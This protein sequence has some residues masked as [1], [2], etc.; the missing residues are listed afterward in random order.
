MDA[1]K[2]ALLQRLREILIDEYEECAFFQAAAQL[3]T[4]K[5]HAIAAMLQEETP[6]YTQLR[7][8][9]GEIGIFLSNAEKR[10]QEVENCYTQL[11]ETLGDFH[12]DDRP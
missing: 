7:D 4:D 12:P 2:Q 1:Q 3:M 5:F 8:T 9:I 11:V 6:A 10:L